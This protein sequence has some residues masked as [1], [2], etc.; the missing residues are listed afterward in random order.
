MAKSIPGQLSMFEPTTSEASRNATSSQASADGPTP[1][2]LPGGPTT[3][4]S[5]P[6]PA[7]ASPSP[8]RGKGKAQQ[9]NDISGL[10]STASFQ[11]ADR[12]SY[13]V[14]RSLQ[15]SGR[16]G[17]TEC[18]LIW[19]VRAT[20][21]GRL[22][23]QLV[24]SMR[25]IGE[26]DFGLWPTPR[27][28]EA[29]PDFAKADRSK[30]GMALPAVAALTAPLWPTPTSLSP[31]KDGNNEAGNSA[32]IRQHALAMWRTPRANDYK[33]GLYPDSDSNRPASDHFLPDQ[34][35]FAMWATPSARDWKDT[36][37]MAQTGIDPD[38]STRSRL[39]Q[40][41]R[42]V[43]AMWPTPRVA[44]VRTGASSMDR[45]DSMSAMSMEQVAEVM[46]GIVPREMEFL[47]P[48]MRERLGLPQASA[49]WPTPRQQDGKHGAATDYEL[50]RETG[51][52]LVHVAA[53]RAH[54][55]MPS[56]SSAQTE[57][58]G[59]LNPAFVSW[60]M[61]FPPEWE[62]CAPLA[63]PSSRKRAPK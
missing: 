53:A 52:D 46:S 2:G 21:A 60:L 30:T 24:P 9:T 7:P 3:G 37:G 20:P 39:D 41:P 25:P 5:G 33:G 61:G 62:S 32:A 22:F 38:G 13:S 58:P 54:G 8:S 12:L 19:K 10:S 56:G 47:R 45:Q 59:A 14:S 26:I 35:N 34:V 48:A 31:A 55:A 15:Q 28:S 51:K 29:G 36:P 42:Q 44:A 11:N 6:D 1:S 50:S 49:M 16:L 23:F 27:A 18:S 4:P 63:M 40:L 43:A 17:S 57:K